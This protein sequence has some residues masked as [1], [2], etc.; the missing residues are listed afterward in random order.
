M[1]FTR[2]LFLLSLLIMGCPAMSQ[3]VLFNSSGGTPDPSALMELRSSDQGFLPPRMEESD[4][5][6]ISAPAQGLTI[7][8]TNGT[9]GYY[10]YN[11]TAWDTLGGATS[12]TNISNVI[13]ASSS[14]IAVIRDEKAASTA[15]GIFTSGAWRRRDLNT[16]AGDVSFLT[17]AAD[18]FL[19]DSGVYVITTSAPAFEVDEHQIRLYNN[20]LSSVAAVG[21]IAYSDKFAASN[22]TLTTVVTVGT[23]GEYFSI[24]HRCSTT[25]ATANGF[26]IGATWGENV[27]TQVKIEK[28]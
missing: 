21:T 12:V 9:I 6:G 8:Q 7:F 26:G 22:S 14:G 27:Y 11:G 13:N 4:R 5:L 18:S 2:T 28:L 10:F 1:I 23:G 25:S 20:S 3:N 19:L 15:G 24:E 17:F 16:S